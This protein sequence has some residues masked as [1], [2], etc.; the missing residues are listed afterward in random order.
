[1]YCSR[2]EDDALAAL[3]SAVRCRAPAGTGRI[4]IFDNTDAVPRGPNAA[5]D[6]LLVKSAPASV[7]P[8]CRRTDAI[9]TM[10][11][12]KNIVYKT[13]NNLLDHLTA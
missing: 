7:L 5:L 1:M 8:G 11:E 10:H 3:A 12:T 4:V 2:Y 6:T 9:S 13:Y